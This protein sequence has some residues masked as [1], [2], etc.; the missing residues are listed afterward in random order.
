MPQRVFLL[1]VFLLAVV[2]GT[3]ASARAAASATTAATAVGHA[4]SV[5]P[6]VDYLEDRS[7]QLTLAEVT[8]PERAADF[9]ALPPGA[10]PNFGL[11]ASVY[12]LRFEL[13]AE[14]GAAADRLLEVAY[15]FLGS[16]V[17]HGPD[18]QT[19]A[20]GAKLP[21][22]T[23]TTPHR[24]FIFPLRLAAGAPGVYHLRVATEGAYT[25]PLRIWQPTAFHDR[26]QDSY[27]L[28][29][30]Y[31]GELLAL[32]LY[33][34]L[35]YL[36]LRDRAYLAYVAFVAAMALTNLSYNG[37]G[38]QYFWPD[39]PGAG[40]YGLPLGLA[41]T[42]IASMQFSRIFLVTARNSPRLD[43]LLKAMMSIFVLA[44]AASP[45]Y[46]LPAFRVMAAS[47]LVFPL[48][49][50]GA[51]I[52][53]LRQGHSPA[54]FFLL[55]WSVLLLGVVLYT[56]RTLG[57]LPANF[58]TLNAIQIGSAI[59]M[60][61][62]SFALADRTRVLVVANAELREREIQLRH[63]AHHDPL[64]G[65][66][67]RLL[68]DDRL[69]HAIGLAGRQGHPLAVLLVDLDK[70]KPVNDTWGHAVG[71]AL[72]KEVAARLLTTVR[73]VDTV[74]RIGGDEFVLVL[75]SLHSLDDARQV[76]EKVLAELSRPVVV[77]GHEL[78]ISGSVGIAFH[79]EPALD[80]R[81]LLKR[82]DMAMYEAKAAGRNRCAIHGGV[83]P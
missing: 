83:A 13:R 62:F 5:V 38:G 74:A 6:Q 43:K 20:S 34:L 59:E 21:F 31:Y 3:A 25:I 11:S 63:A 73:G 7:G 9:R 2:L 76:A 53:S 36:S 28:L 8:A 47:G 48:V 46:L 52:V 16:V 71:D 67:N 49:C 51:G 37:L 57:V 18:G 23:R 50:L 54:R 72:L 41:A 70:F 15:P 55:G 22:E 40:R 68:L 65:L 44:A 27:L 24:H 79:D 10:E 33:N 4:N 61:L 17:L 42:A 26:A 69:D 19:I 29:G 30:L 45:F 80:A 35:L 58:F 39:A 78:H 1:C 66:A 14:P 77:D 75:E 56:L 82:A 12:W 81:E 60:L 32:L 64:T